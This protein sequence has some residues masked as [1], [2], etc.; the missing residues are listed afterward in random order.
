MIPVYVLG[1][2]VSIFFCGLTLDIGRMELLRVQM[3]NAAEAAA[4][5]AEIEAERGTSTWAAFGQQEASSNGFTDGVDNTTVTLAQSPNS[6]LYQGRYD[7][8]QSTITHTFHTLF[9]GVLNGGTYTVIVQNSA[10]VAPC[11]YFLGGSSAQYTYSLVESNTTFNSTCPIYINQNFSADSTSSLQGFGVNVSGS[12]GS[13]NDVGTDAQQ[14]QGPTPSP[15]ALAPTYGVRVVT[16]PLSTYAQPIAGGCSST[17]R[18]IAS[19]SVTLSPGTYC[20]TS[21]T[22]GLTISNA[23]VT[24][25]PGTYIITGGMTWN[26]A[27]VTGTGVTL[28][29]T[30]GSNGALYGQVLIGTSAACTL[31]L[32]APTATANNVQSILFWLDRNW[33]NTSATDFQV[34]GN[35]SFS[36]D[37]IWYMP[38]TGLSIS[39]QPINFTHY[40]SFVA[41]NAVFSNTTLTTGQD[42]SALPVGS[43]FR[44]QGGIVQ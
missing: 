31:N 27:T 26:N 42:V 3:Q 9:M 28:Y 34:A 12:S 40:G 5:G 39:T 10:L 17:S 32:T 41:R 1:I 6:G 18:S 11:N 25:N 22:P 36:G 38:F 29:F 23:T 2:L 33:T 21:S 16:D 30:K 35:G 8:I 19:G 44:Q 20:G 4:V 24:L 15:P 37:G 13:S 43:H 14:T 7:A